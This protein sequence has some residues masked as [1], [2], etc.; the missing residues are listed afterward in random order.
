MS[1]PREFFEGV[2][3]PSYEAWLFDPLTEWKA[4]S[5]VSNADILGERL[6]VYWET[7]DVSQVAEA[8]SASKY[9]THLRHNGSALS[10]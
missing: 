9:R 8:T 5:A 7:G 10:R 3:K 2:A 4:K 1:T 6:F